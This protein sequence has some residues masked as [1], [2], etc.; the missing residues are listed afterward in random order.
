MYQSNVVD[1]VAAHRV[2]HVGVDDDVAKYGFLDGE[3]T[4]G[5]RLVEQLVVLADVLLGR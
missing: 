4:R 1:A 3:Q 2:H 5:L